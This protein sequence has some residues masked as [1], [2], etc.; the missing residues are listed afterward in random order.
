M[1]SYMLVVIAPD[2]AFKIEGHFD[3]I[4]DA[5]KRSEDMGTRWYFYPFHFVAEAHGDNRIVESPRFLKY[6]DG[7][8]LKDAAELIKAMSDDE[9]NALLS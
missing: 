9:K 3:S 2:G 8:T 1:E 7:I 6:M 4:D 5:W